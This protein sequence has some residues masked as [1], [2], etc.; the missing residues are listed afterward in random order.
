MRGPDGGPAP[1]GV[2]VTV[3]SL[4]NTFR[5]A[6]LTV[7]VGDE[8]VFDNVGRNEHNVIPEPDSLQGWGIGDADFPPGATYSHVFDEP[9]EYR[10]VCT[11]HGVKGKGMVGTIIVTP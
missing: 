1:T 5:P 11:I 6:A 9:G 7:V 2:V 8:V 3:Q 10:Y 4:D